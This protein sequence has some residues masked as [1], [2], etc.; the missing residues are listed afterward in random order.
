MNETR[1]AVSCVDLQ[2][3]TAR[4]DSFNNENWTSIVCRDWQSTLLVTSSNKA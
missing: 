3:P 4:S 1:V 2:V